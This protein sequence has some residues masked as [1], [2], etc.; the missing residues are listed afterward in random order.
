MSKRIYSRIAGTGSYL[1]EKVLTNADLEK[2]VE[3]SDEW[4]QTRT[5]IRERH[6][7]AEGETTSDL[8]YQ[9]AL[10]ALEAAGIDAS[11]LDM[12]VVGTTTPDLIFPSTA[13]LIQA[14]LGASGCPAFDVNAACSGFVFALSVAD[15]FIRSGDARHV[16]VIGTE[17]L[18]RI[19]DWEDR[20]TCVLFGDGAGAVVLKADE[21]TGILSTHLHSDGSKKELLWNPVGVSVGFKGGANGGGTI[22]M[23]GNDVFK[24][25]VKA[26]DSVVDETLEAN[27]LDKSDLDW[28]IPH[29]ANLRIIEAT[30]KR[31]DMS[32]DQVVVTVDRHGNTS[33][34][35]VPL[36]LDAAVRS[37]KVERGQLLLL[38]AFGGGFTW[39][40][41]LLR[42]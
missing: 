8:G 40:S 6:I 41:A 34:A 26:L 24:Y 30:A 22:N 23:K 42:Y 17:T 15:K 14:K 33:S 20:T 32:M 28:L 37:G 3:T 5:G 35:S 36:A 13:C 29:Q 27:G 19:V 9:A 18:T 7:A 31:L 2:M 11:Q 4:I 21:E 25:A 39:G 12:I 16:L 1:P 10:R 38:E